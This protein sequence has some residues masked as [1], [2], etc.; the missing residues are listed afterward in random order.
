MI[1]KYIYLFFIILILASCEESEKEKIARLINE[2]SR[3][4][5]SYPDNLVFSVL[6]K[7]TIDYS[8]PHSNYTI[9]SYVDSIGCMSCKLQL[10][11]WKEF[12]EELDSLCTE[13]IPI[14]MFMHPTNKKAMTTILRKH[15]FSYPVCI[16]MDDRMNKL[17]RF[18]DDMAFQTFLL[19]KDSKV[20]AIGNPVHNP[21]VKELYLNIILG[22]KAPKQ[23]DPKNRTKITMNT[24]QTDLRKFNWKEEQTVHFTLNN[25]GEKPLII[26]Q[27][28]TSCGCTTVDYS[29]EPVRPGN[30]LDIQVKYKADTPGY[31][32]K[33]ITVY[34][35][36]ELSP[37]KFSITGD[38]I[39][40]GV[41]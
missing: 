38:A 1:N 32:N 8:L 11:E 37:V 22:D 13:K 3:K 20:I 33:T 7:D 30:S 28:N 10:D 31:F 2:W 35:N 15:N 6:E 40:L 14:L 12:I 19:D 41:Q 4:D 29:K 24:P 25:V 27:V 9:V 5:I 39:E 16:D 34:C 17:N 21:K 23:S 36:A 26:D 18:P